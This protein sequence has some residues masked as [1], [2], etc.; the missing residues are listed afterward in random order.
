[1]LNSEEWIRREPSLLSPSS[2]DLLALWE[3]ETSLFSLDLFFPRFLSLMV[4]VLFISAGSF[5]LNQVQ[6]WAI[7]KEMPRTQ[8][9]P[10]PKGE[11]TISRAL[12]I[13]VFLLMVGEG[14]LFNLKPLVGALGLTTVTSRLQN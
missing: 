1:M 3:P 4:G 10:I 7:D 5:A 2:R 6:E 13:S 11:I 9:R 8:N 14:I 12:M